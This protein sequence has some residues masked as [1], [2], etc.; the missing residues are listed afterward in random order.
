LHALRIGR[1]IPNV[2]ES[3]LGDRLE[4]SAS[5]SFIPLR[6]SLAIPAE[7]RRKCLLASA[8]SPAT[9][10]V[11]VWREWGNLPMQNEDEDL[12]Q[13]SPDRLRELQ[14][15]VLSLIEEIGSR[16]GS[17]D[18]NAAEEIQELDELLEEIE[19]RLSSETSEP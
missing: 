5:S 9:S 4:S 12:D 11:R 15:E 16:D 2:H 6:M 14:Q 7:T 10:R 3:A 18:P 17:V 19:I 1:Q 13:M 8:R